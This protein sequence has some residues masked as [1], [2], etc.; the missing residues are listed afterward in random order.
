LIDKELV[1]VDLN[2]LT[3]I[4]AITLNFESKNSLP[5]VLR[6]EGKKNDYI[7]IFHD[8]ELEMVTFQAAFLNVESRSIDFILKSQ[9]PRVQLL[10]DSDKKLIHIAYLAGDNKNISCI[11]VKLIE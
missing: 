1:Q 4:N 6:I 9:R 2:Q 11:D 5:E 3:T 7:L 8:G 10:P